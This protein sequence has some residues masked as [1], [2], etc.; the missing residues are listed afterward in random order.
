M[1]ETET[2]ATDR[3]AWASRRGDK[4]PEPITASQLDW[5]KV[6]YL[7][8]RKLPLV[9][10]PRL[11][12]VELPAWITA[13][14]EWMLGELAVHGGIL[15]RGFDITGQAEFERFL[16]PFASELVHYREGATPRTE[17]GNHVYTSTEFPA[18]QAIALHNELSYVN[19]WPMKIWFFCLR[20]PEEGG[21]TPI[22]DMR[23]VLQRIP[24][25]IR[26]RFEDLGWMLVRNLGYGFGPG[27]QSAY[28]VETRE[29]AEEYFRG[30]EIEF[31]WKEGDRL[32]TR[33]VRPAVAVH[34]RT[35]EAVWFNHV[36]FWHASSLE[37]GLRRMFTQELG[38]DGLPYSTYYG[39]GSSINDEVAGELRHAYEEEIVAFPWQQGD[40]L[41]LDNMLVAH[42]RQPFKGPRRILTAMGEPFKRHLTA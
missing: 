18:D 10:E 27:W 3:R 41:M 9:I 12:S 11:K 25:E 15:F 24:A 1:P 29:E 21:A 34:P 39:D 31:E 19:T 42:G 40:V 7:D 13:N 37:P 35:G 36:A 33:Q 17:L 14:R 2:K 16:A 22:A 26:E 20:P 38:E 30:A 5:V 6:G 23:R 8:E 4:K 32:K 28:R